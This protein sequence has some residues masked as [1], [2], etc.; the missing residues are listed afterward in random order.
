ME[1]LKT[2]FMKVGR[3]VIIIGCAAVI[4]MFDTIFP[5]V[6]GDMR[7]L[8]MA[9]FG[10]PFILCILTINPEAIKREKKANKK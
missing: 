10:I 1:L 4:F 3:W 9:A 2:F 7:T 5:E 6:T 8:L